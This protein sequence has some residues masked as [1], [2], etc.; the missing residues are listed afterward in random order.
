MSTESAAE[1]ATAFILVVDDDPRIRQAIRWALEEEGFVVE[2]AADGRQAPERAVG[3][4]PALVVLDMR[5]PV[6]DGATVADG[7]RAAYGEPPPIIL[8]TADDRAE[9][10]ARR[11]GAYAHLP[12]P[13]DLDELI[14][15][16]QRGLHA[17]QG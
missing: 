10:K 5:L 2:T 12:K 7:L 11:V 17:R 3:V 14:A 1:P 9:E 4:R 6:V 8:I 16:I 15:T 13:F